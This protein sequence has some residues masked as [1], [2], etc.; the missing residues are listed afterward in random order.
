MNIRMY[1]NKDKN[2]LNTF[3]VI[4]VIIGLK[5]VVKQSGMLVM[6]LDGTYSQ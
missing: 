5:Y 3:R 4:K 2:R 1:K 6:A